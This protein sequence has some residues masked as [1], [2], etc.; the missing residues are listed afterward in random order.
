MMETK[1]STIVMGIGIAYLVIMIIA[2]PQQI[3]FFDAFAPPNWN[4]AAGA[5]GWCC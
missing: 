5:A 4:S 3:E 2:T 1:R